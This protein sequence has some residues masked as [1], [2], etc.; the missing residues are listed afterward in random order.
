[1]TQGLTTTSL[2]LGPF[3]IDRRIG[4]GGMGAIYRGQHRD[5]GTPI[6]IKV[7]L[8]DQARNPQYYE[9]FLSEIRSVARLDHP[10][11][12]RVHDYGMIPG[13]LDAATDGELAANS[14]WLAMELAHGSLE[15]RSF[16][17]RHGDVVHTLLPILRAVGH[18]HARG[19][20]HRDLKPGNVLLVRRGDGER[21]ALSDFG[22]A[23]ASERHAASAPLESNALHE[24]PIGTPAFMAPEQFHGQWRDYGPWTDLYQL[25]I[26]AWQMF[27]G[28]LPFQG[29]SHMELAFAHMRAPLPPL[30]HHRVEAPPGLD[31]WLQ[32]MCAKEPGARFR[33]AADA[34]WVLRDIAFRAGLLDRS[35]SLDTTATS[36]IPPRIHSESTGPDPG[37]PHTGNTAPDGTLRLGEALDNAHASPLPATAERTRSLGHTAP[38]GVQAEEPEEAATPVDARTI[39]DP[40]RLPG[41]PPWPD[42]PPEDTDGHRDALLSGAGAGLFGLRSIPLV[43][44][45][46]ARQA[47]WDQ[48]GEV[49]RSL[50]PKLCLI[51]GGPGVGKSRLLQWLCETVH[52]SGLATPMRAIH[53]RTRGPAHGL[54]RMIANVHRAVG[55]PRD[56]LLQRLQA[57]LQRE[58]VDS[59]YEWEAL[60]E[61]LVDT[62]SGTNA[63]GAGPSERRIRF[64]D[65]SERHALIHRFLERQCM[66]RPIV[67]W[68]DDLHFGS[69]TL[70]FLRHI[71]LDGP[72][73][74][75]PALF[76]A[77]IRDDLLQERPLEQ[78]LLQEFDTRGDVRRLALD[79][80]E[81]QDHQTLVRNLLGLEPRL[82]QQ[83]HARAAGN[84]LFAIQLVGD[85]VERR[86]LEPTRHG[87]RLR[88]GSGAGL[89]DDLHHLWNQRIDYVLRDVPPDADT[90]FQLVAALGL[91][92]DLTE[93]RE[94]ARRVDIPVREEA[95]HAMV[96]AGLLL[97]DG[98]TWSLAHPLL[99]DSFER[100]AVEAGRWAYLQRAT[101]AAIRTVHPEDTLGLSA[102]R[103]GHLLAAGDLE[104]ALPLL[105]HAVREAID[106]GNL[107]ASRQLVERYEATL[108]QL[109]IP[110]QD[111]RRIR[112]HELRADVAR[113]LWDFAEA[114][115][116]AERALRLARLS[117]AD[118]LLG[119]VLVLL[120]NIRR[121]QA[122]PQE[123]EALADEALDHFGR[124]GD[125][126]GLARAT[127]TR[128]ILHRVCQRP[129]K[130]RELYEESRRHFEHI[131]D[132]HGVA[133]C[134]QGLGNLARNLRDLDTAETHYRDSAHHFHSLGLLNEQALSINGLAEVARFRGQL[135]RAAELYGQALDIQRSLGDRSES[136]TRLNLAL[137]RIQRE[138]IDVAEEELRALEKEMRAS[139]Q[140]GLLPYV[141]IA[142]VACAGHRGDPLAWHHFL[143]LADEGVTASSLVDTDIALCAEIA[144]SAMRAQG[145]HDS[146][147]QA[148]ALAI[149]QYTALGDTEALDRLNTNATP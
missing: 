66:E 83:V 50:R 27:T 84:P 117:R 107:P 95:R 57:E 4:Q 142:L 3:E 126:E 71:L 118:D 82:A 80:L 22:I 35:T 5:S 23:H 7:I 39:R 99:R 123:A 104:D 147:D 65:D 32:R 138:H 2:M 105:D 52:A 120:A 13:H 148:L 49:R 9:D 77:T 58:H 69:D 91:S 122:R 61:L 114:S 145:Q 85:W 92:A 15:D 79:V 127:L 144:A 34:A 72:P 1:M 21:I 17:G 30:A 14:P 112:G 73:P 111:Q 24:T 149:A 47:L 89:P 43:D 45:E 129:E 74:L 125:E 11:I 67:V 106:N 46:Q 81:P 25:G 100:R 133:G 59:T 33:R 136:I 94:A 60:T 140:T 121:Q 141:H 26:M 98:D 19:V 97:T 6:A 102:R 90:L 53:E 103:A 16:A 64:S 110:E 113:L 54:P 18:A 42:H 101:E 44:R 41:Q 137:V 88:S 119:R 37:P 109:R 116:H 76:V 78:S 28:H 86:V 31:A 51:Q 132:L 75:L 124:L 93:L 56:T 128:A 135:D 8:S 134:I 48:L 143:R 40:L 130:A 139:G 20:I 115:E 96:S 70:G 62:A 68:L 131:D 146:A 55:L 10:G 29:R 108:D 36:A 12:I 38:V 63:P 87:F